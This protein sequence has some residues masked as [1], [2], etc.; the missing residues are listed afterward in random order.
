MVADAF[1]FMRAL[2]VGSYR[3]I[4]PTD[5]PRIERDAV[6]SGGD[7]G[8][9][10]EGA[11]TTRVFRRYAAAFVDDPD[12]AGLFSEGIGPAVYLYPPVF[13]AAS[14]NAALVGYRTI[15]TQNEQ[16]FTDEAYAD[17]SVFQNQLRRIARP[18]AFSNEATGLRPSD[19]EGYFRFEAGER[20]HRHVK[21]QALVLCS[22]EPYSYGSFLF[23]V[24]PKIRAFRDLALKDARIIVYAQQKPFMDLLNL[25]GV[26]KEAIL[27]HEID[28]VTQIDRAVIPGLRG[29]HAYHDP[30]SFDVFAEIRELHGVP[31][32][33]RRVYVSR[34]GLGKAGW[35]S[36]IMANESQLIDRL[37][38]MGFDIVEPE[39]LSVRDQIKLFSSASMVVGPSGSGLFNTVF[40]HP[41]TKIIDIQ[42]EPQWIYSYTGMYSSLKLDYGIFIGKADPEDSKPMHRRWSVNIEALT[43]RIKKFIE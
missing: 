38:A 27:L 9:Y 22:D 30:E 2:G 5:L 24:V 3:P 21:G 28:W 4:N 12:D 25:C 34:Y 6:I 37:W 43:A 32:T 40:C 16:F 23:R 26:P 13:T 35:T 19:G 31:T 14:S 41:G 1:D 11:G 15:L 10:V 42:S 20:P 39:H 36:R 17:P 18:D 29:P 33:G 7:D 8:V